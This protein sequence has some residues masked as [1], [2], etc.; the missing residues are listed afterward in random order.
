MTD[1]PQFL[2]M[3]NGVNMSVLHAPQ[4]FV[5]FLHVSRCFNRVSLAPLIAYP[6]TW[7]SIQKM[8]VLTGSCW[9]L[10]FIV[11]N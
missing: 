9:E 11:K 4:S 8:T 3:S 6:L 7:C 2:G 1:K 5:L 10:C